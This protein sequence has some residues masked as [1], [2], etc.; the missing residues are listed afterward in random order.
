ME[1]YKYYLIMQKEWKYA[2]N[3]HSYADSKIEH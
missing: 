2:D 3:P 1:N